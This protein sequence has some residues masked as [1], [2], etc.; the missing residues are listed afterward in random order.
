MPSLAG[1]TLRN[2]KVLPYSQTKGEYFMCV[3]VKRNIW[4]REDKQIN[5]T[6]NEKNI[7]DTDQTDTPKYRI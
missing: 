5:G 4:T 3:T 1:A 6:E 2:S 7:L